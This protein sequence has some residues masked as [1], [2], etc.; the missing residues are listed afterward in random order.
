MIAYIDGLRYFISPCYALDDQ[1]QQI[2][3]SLYRLG[4]D[5]RSK[6]LAF[7]PLRSFG[8]LK[9]ILRRVKNEL[10]EQMLLICKDRKALIN[11]TEMMNLLVLQKVWIEL[12]ADESLK[13]T[14][15]GK[16]RA[17]ETCSER[18]L[19]LKSGR[20]LIGLF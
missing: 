19:K 10:G 4:R 7:P 9:Q 13:E 17:E 5:S 2:R 6:S 14:G 20:M 1:S 11:Q 8:G 15:T 18:S 16:R 3:R 12:R